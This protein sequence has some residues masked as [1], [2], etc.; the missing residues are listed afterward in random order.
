[1]AADEN[2]QVFVAARPQGALRPTDFGMRSAPI[3]APRAGEALARIL[4]L[5][6]DPYMRGHLDGAYPLMKPLLVGDTMY[7]AAV[8]EVIRSRSP[9]LPEGTYVEGPLGWQTHAV[10]T[11]DQVR[12]VDPALAPLSTALGVLGMP[13]MTAYFGVTEIAQPRD[14]ETFLV[15][16]AAGTVGSAAGQI[17]RILGCRTVG[18]AGSAG[19]VRTLTGLFGFAAGID[20]RAVPDLHAAIAAACPEKLDIYFD[21]VGGAT[22]DATVRWMKMGFRYVICGSI[23]SYDDPAADAGP[24][25]LKLLETHRARILGF[26]VREYRPR[27]EEGI[28][29]M[30]AWIRSGDLR[31]QEEVF[32]G[33]ET[34]PQA[35]IG[36]LRGEN[37]GK[38][39]IRVAGQ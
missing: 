7:G 29:R 22:Y 20:Y 1:M 31:Y 18:I 13:G 8:A 10:V 30:A 6:V 39:V 33:L 3:P 4:Y 35:L 24:R 17:A 14:G 9:D 36:L 2:R 26:G 32:D 11:P 38:R 37:I 27:Y 25:H 16:S 5:S 21:N 23:A 12:R 34:A 19:K 15:S 28:A